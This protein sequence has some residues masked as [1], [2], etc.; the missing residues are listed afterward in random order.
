MDRRSLAT[1][2]KFKPKDINQ[3]TKIEEQAFPKTAYSK[4]TFLSYGTSFPDTF[5]VIETQDD[6]V[7]Y[8]IFDRG[9]HI[10]S[11]AVKRTYRMKGFGRMLFMH[12]AKY[13]RK[14]LRLEVRSKNSGAIAFYKSLGM[15]ITGK[16]S[17][18]YGSDDALI[19]VMNQ[20]E[21]D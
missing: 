11:T 2:R 16:I 9:G 4:Q 5:C 21:L 12:A 15:K 19:M 6:I 17:N 8:I 13:A 1:I 10:H 7:G 3:I 18:Y 14:R 20:K